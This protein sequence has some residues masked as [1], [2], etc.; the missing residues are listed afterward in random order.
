[1]VEQANVLLHKGDA[2]LLGSLEN[3]S[4]VLAAAGGGDVLDARSGGT[5]N[6]VDEGE[7]QH[8]LVEMGWG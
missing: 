6:V 7:L 8:A 2:K 5:E 3:C 1:M 4:V